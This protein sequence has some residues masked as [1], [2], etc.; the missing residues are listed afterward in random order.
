LFAKYGHSLPSVFLVD[1]QGNIRGRW[2]GF[3]AATGLDV[4]RAT[5][6]LLGITR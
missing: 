2:E 1:A 5:E 3:D 4:E 6:T